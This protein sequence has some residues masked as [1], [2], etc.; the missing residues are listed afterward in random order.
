MRQ[1]WYFVS[2][3]MNKLNEYT[4]LR[5][6]NFQH[7]NFFSKHKTEGSLTIISNFV[8]SGLILTQ[9]AY[10]INKN[11]LCKIINAK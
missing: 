7:D 1:L 3:D 6:E 10:D 5:L 2:T 9:V 8:K 4:R 11:T